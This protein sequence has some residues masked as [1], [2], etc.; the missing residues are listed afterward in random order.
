M[1]CKCR[2]QLC[3]SIM[4]FYY[5][6]IGRAILSSHCDV[7]HNKREVGHV[8]ETRLHALLHSLLGTSLPGDGWTKRNIVW[9]EFFDTRKPSC[10]GFS[11]HMRFF[12]RRTSLWN[13]IFRDWRISRWTNLAIDESPDGLIPRG[14]TSRD[15]SRDCFGATHWVATD[16]RK[17]HRETSI[18]EVPQLKKFH[19][20]DENPI[21]NWRTW[22]DHYGLCHSAPNGTVYCSTDALHLASA[23]NIPDCTGPKK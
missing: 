3:V 7:W 20:P 4:I 5:T 9:P 6:F 11:R 17:K 13:F 22:C 2:V 1:T 10:L 15:S 19:D 12:P 8:D 21:E 23:Q 14:W 16:R 18:A